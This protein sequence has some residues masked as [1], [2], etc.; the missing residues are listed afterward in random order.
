MLQDLTCIVDKCT[1]LLALKRG[2]DLISC[3][4][5]CTF[6]CHIEDKR[7]ESLCPKLLLKPVIA[8]AGFRGLDRFER[9]RLAVLTEKLL[10][11]AC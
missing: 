1:E 10:G 5:D 2:S 3:L 6:V 7:C 8:I 9:L 4:A 11:S